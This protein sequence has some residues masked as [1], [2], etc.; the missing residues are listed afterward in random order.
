MV[1]LTAV[2]SSPYGHCHSAVFSA[3]YGHCH[4]A[5]Y[6][7]SAVVMNVTSPR[8]ASRQN[9][10]AASH[11]C[12][13]NAVLY[14]RSISECQLPSD[15]SRREIPGAASSIQNY[16]N[17]FSVTPLSPLATLQT[18]QHIYHAISSLVQRC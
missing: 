5:P 4:S 6:R 8:T 13:S 17:F 1:T 10:A 12:H 3:P 15:R 7:H 14:P 9:D 11:S 16:R 2:F 18:C